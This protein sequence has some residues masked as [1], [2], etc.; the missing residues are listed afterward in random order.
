MK[1]WFYVVLG[2][3]G[4]FPVRAQEAIR[5]FSPGQL[6]E[7][8]KWEEQA[9]KLPEPARVGGYMK[10][11][12]AKPHLAGTPASKAVADYALGLMKQW[13]LDAHLEEY[14][15]L[16]PV[17]KARLLEMVAPHAFRAK[18]AEPPISADPTSAD[19]DEAPTYNAYSGSGDVTAPLIYANYGMPGDYDYLAKNGIDVKGRIVLTR[20][21]GGWRGLKPKLAAEHGALGCL[22]YSDPKD[23]GY[24]RG[25]VYPRGM[26]RPADGV[27][28]GSVLD[29]T[30]YPGDPLSPGWASEK[31]SKRLRLSE[32]RTLMKIPVLPISYGDA[33]PF[34]RE[35]A[36]L[37]APEDWRGALGITYHIG[38]GNT[39]VRLK[40]DMDNS[41]HPIYDVIAS[42]P[43]SDFPDEWVMAGNHHDAWVH[44]AMDPLSGASALLETA[45]TLAELGKRGW[46]PRRTIKIALWDGEEFGLI[47]STEFAE[48]HAAELSKKLIAYINSDTTSKGQLGAGGSHTLE[49]FVA[50][51]TRDVS[52]PVT[53]KPLSEN[54]RA[55]SS[56]QTA[57]LDAAQEHPSEWHLEA[58]G[59]GSDYASFL[60]HLGIA[61]LNFGFGDMNGTGGIY[62]SAYDSYYWYTHFADTNFTYGKTLSAFTSLGL[63]RLGGASLVPFQFTRLVSTLSQYEEEIEKLGK[64]DKRTSLSDLRSEIRE[65]RKSAAEFEAS[66]AYA[67]PRLDAAP[68][69]VLAAINEKI[70]TSERKMLLD[71]GLPRR[72]WYRHAIYA[73][74]SLTGYGVKTLPGIREA[75][76]AGQMK[77]AQQQTARVIEV[78]RGI[79]QQIEEAAQMLSGL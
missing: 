64:G 4:C 37:V 42:I 67:L 74:G 63:M 52:D 72:E 34:M 30:L 46:R 26:W 20:Y 24:Y 71:A 75:V 40:V 19:P 15:A 47:G 23:D 53:G 59:S 29:I 22:I 9:R 21:G 78:L 58:L 65:L 3:T 14:D 61:S 48:K 50:D 73:P 76:E 1:V 33:L 12:S 41:V 31:D 13:G 39:Q 49:A 68:K 51:L 17:P 62:H 5:G 45:R 38:N 79:N 11:M 27:Q 16:L 28:R 2:L 18:L 56:G 70:F 25:D 35:L 6:T 69:D 66:Y 8:K 7:E 44:G 32:V 60:Q 57:A 77:E 43:G 55:R 36:G 54:M 10:Q